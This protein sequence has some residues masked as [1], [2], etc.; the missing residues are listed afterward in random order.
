MDNDDSPPPVVAA[1][2]S[3][4]S[5]DSKESPPA[6]GEAVSV[7]DQTL[8]CVQCGSQFVFSAEEQEFFASRELTE[9]PKRCRPCRAER[10]KARRGRGR[11]GRMKDYR[12]PAFRE[13]HK[14][15][16]LYRS[17]AFQKKQDVD[18]IYRS[19]AFKEELENPEEI[20]RSPGFQQ[21]E[22]SEEIYRGPAFQP[23]DIEDE[24]APQEDVAVNSGEHDLE[25][26]PP[27]GYREPNSP[28]EIYRSPAFSD[29]DPAGYAPS[30]KRR[31]MHDIVCADC[32]RKSKVPFKPKKD[33]AV[34]CKD[35]F[36]KKR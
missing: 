34:Y 35:C 31:Q 30:Y 27:P 6:E 3:D 25:E 33:K 18:S 19:P 20:Y 15:D 2:D 21:E 28:H 23:P 13:K 16:N 1:E 24:E 32:G 22:S 9:P 36:T 11:R 8:T 29:T 4:D 10:R 14:L 17:P 26:G 7:E 12:S 5:S